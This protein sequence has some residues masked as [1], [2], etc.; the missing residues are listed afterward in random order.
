MPNIGRDLATIERPKLADDAEQSNAKR[1]LTQPQLVAYWSRIKAME[2]VTGALLRFHLLTGAQRCT[3]LARLAAHHVTDDAVTIY[4]PKGRRKQAR[5]HVVPL[6]P[7]AAAALGAMRGNEGPYVF[8]MDGGKSGAGFHQVRRKVLE[9]A[10]DMVAAKEVPEV[11]TPGELRITVE[12]R[13]AAA[14]VP[15]EHRAQLQSHGLGGVQ[16][17]HYDKHGYMDEKRAALLKLRA[18]CEPQPDNVTPIKR[19]K[20]A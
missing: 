17:K 3:Q 11:F 14:G 20:A 13:L 10:A 16:F 1:E 15:L 8:T 6:L 9:V 12:T 2:G 4:D 19:S 18:L 5:K 7:E